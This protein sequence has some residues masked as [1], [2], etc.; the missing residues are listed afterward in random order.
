[1]VGRR[2]ES[3][4]ALCTIVS[5]FTDAV[6]QTKGRP[7]TKES[8]TSTMAAAQG[9]LNN[10][11]R[12]KRP[13]IVFGLSIKALCSLPPPLIP[14]QCTPLSLDPSTLYITPSSKP[15]EQYPPD[16]ANRLS[17]LDWLWDNRRSNR[18]GADIVGT[19]R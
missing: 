5:L 8:R 18:G 2:S 10:L 4:S 12:A 9:R 15:R 13:F 11:K 14:L 6:Q 19:G 3:L 16:F 17:L 1:M 7:E